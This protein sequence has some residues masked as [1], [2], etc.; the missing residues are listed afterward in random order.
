MLKPV[1]SLALTSAG[2]KSIVLVKNFDGQGRSE[3]Q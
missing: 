1:W 3:S 2:G